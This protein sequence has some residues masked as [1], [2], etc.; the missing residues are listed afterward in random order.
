MEKDALLA[1]PRY[2]LGQCSLAQGDIQAA[3]TYLASEAKLAGDDADVLVSMASMFL[4]IA[5]QSPGEPDRDEALDY[6]A[7]CLLRA[8]DIDPSDADAYYYLG[9]ANAMKGEF[10][11]AAEFFTHALDINPLHVLAIRDSAIVYLAMQRLDEAAQIVERGSV[12]VGD[13]PQLK[14][15]RRKVRRSQIARQ[16]ADLFGHI[17]H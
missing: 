11:D 13:H 4:V 9:L 2:R 16:L 8:I 3:K 17:K 15:I 10:E 1:G 6:A 7:N 14:S 12:V 5:G